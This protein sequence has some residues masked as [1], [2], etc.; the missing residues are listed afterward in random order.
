MVV[1]MLGKLNLNKKAFFLIFIIL[2]QIILV[3]SLGVCSYLFSGGVSGF[4]KLPD[5]V[6]LFI[7]VF[8]GLAFVAISLI[9]VKEVGRLVEGDILAR[10]QMIQLQK[11][12]EMIRVLRIH[13]HD[14]I[15]HL[16]VIAGLVQLKRHDEVL[17]YVSEVTSNL[18]LA[19]RI[20]NVAK[21]ELA[22]LF[23]T[24][25]SELEEIGAE[26]KVD[27]RS[28]LAELAVNSSEL[29]Q[30]IGNLLDNAIFALK[31]AD[32]Y[33]RWLRL[34]ICENDTYYRFVIANSGSFIPTELHE[35][36][37]MPGYTTKDGKDSGFGLYIVSSLV[38]KYKGGVKVLSTL[39]EGTTFEVWLPKGKVH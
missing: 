3:L 34:E 20:I 5:E 4:P 23:L 25:L 10:D 38:K 29:V 17:N 13:R 26:T 33:E 2:T 30:I 6:H 24:K 19:G 37:F 14:F 39:E 12:E 1:D 21:P 22:A 16:Q 11:A 8:I 32:N 15:N 27:V 31:E 36:I 28:S 9:L 18:L 35:K 7:F